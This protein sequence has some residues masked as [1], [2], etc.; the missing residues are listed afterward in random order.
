[1]MIRI[2]LGAWSSVHSV[3]FCGMHA[4][5]DNLMCILVF[6]RRQKLE[7]FLRYRRVCLVDNAAFVEIEKSKCVLSQSSK[8]SRNYYVQLIWL[9]EEDRSIIKTV[10]K[11]LQ[12]QSVKSEY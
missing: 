11:L 7:W 5:V 1:M 6:V 10:Q 12:S 9:K 2:L 4:N 8:S 3:P